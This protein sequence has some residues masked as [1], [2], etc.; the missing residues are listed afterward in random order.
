MRAASSVSVFVSRCGLESSLLILFQPRNQELATYRDQTGVFF[1]SPHD[2][3]QTYFP[4]KVNPLFPPSPFPTSIPGVPAPSLSN[5]DAYPW[6]HEWPR[7]LVFFGAL[8]REEGVR[9]LLEEKGF[10]EV[11]KKGREWEGEGYRTGG[12]RVWKWSG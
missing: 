9:T 1:D 11:W 5:S 10:R 2:Y 12:V 3:L 6:T 7:Y 4:S 8:L